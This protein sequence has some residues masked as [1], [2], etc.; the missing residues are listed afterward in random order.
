MPQTLPAFSALLVDDN[1]QLWARE[2]DLDAA[3][4]QRWI[5]FGAEGAS[6]TVRVPARF[7]LSAVHGGRV[8]GVF[9]D[10]LDIESIRV[11]AFEGL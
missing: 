7:T 1:N 3:A 6:G 11:Y 8:W 5:V 4:E 10:E 9:R 2:F